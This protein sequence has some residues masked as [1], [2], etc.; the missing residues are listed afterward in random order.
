MIQTKAKFMANLSN[1]RSF[2]IL[3]N[4][5]IKI[6]SIVRTLKHKFNV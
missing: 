4:A 5:R 3:K 2:E 6:N 1:A